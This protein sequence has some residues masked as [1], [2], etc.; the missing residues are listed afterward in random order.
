MRV[1]GQF[2]IDLNR[3][4][5]ASDKKKGAKASEKSDT[6]KGDEV[7]LSSSAK[8]ASGI[9][10]SLKSAPDIRVELVHEL[11]VK[12]ESGQYNVSGREVAEKIVQ[13]AVDDLF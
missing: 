11:K 6:S 1:D 2:N 13:T 9:K 5:E 10:D 8:D 12:I 3:M 4:N 7:S